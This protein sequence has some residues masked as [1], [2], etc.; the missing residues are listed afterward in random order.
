MCAKKRIDLRRTYIIVMRNNGEVNPKIGK[1]DWNEGGTIE[2]S[3]RF[4]VTLL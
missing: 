4:S 1:N 2:L 3:L